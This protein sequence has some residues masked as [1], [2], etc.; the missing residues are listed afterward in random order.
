MHISNDLLD[1]DLLCH[2]GP[3]D[4]VDECDKCWS[5]ATDLS[6]LALRQ[7]DPVSLRAAHKSSDPYLSGLCA[8]S[9]NLSWWHYCI[10]TLMLDRCWV[11]LCCDSVVDFLACS[12]RDDVAVIVFVSKMFPVD[13][14][15]LP[16][17]RTRYSDV[18]D[19]DLH[20]A[21]SVCVI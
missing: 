19:D 8:K 9:T 20:A 13:V 18:T 10:V 3:A 17:N 11:P 16:Q 1:I 2:E 15:S 12:S 4:L 5:I 14:K 21:R 6:Q 7:H